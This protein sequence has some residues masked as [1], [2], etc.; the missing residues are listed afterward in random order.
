M[1]AQENSK[2]GAIFTVT[3]ALLLAEIQA[4][5]DGPKYFGG[6]H[7][8]STQSSFYVKQFLNFDDIDH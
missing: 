3:A 2:K 5:T 7:R 1:I 8:L 6:I 4:T